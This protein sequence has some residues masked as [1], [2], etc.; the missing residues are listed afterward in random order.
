MY[1]VIAAP[2]F[3]AGAVN[4]TVAW[5]LPGVAVTPVGAPGA[6][7]AAGTTAFDA[8]EGALFPTELCAVTV[9]V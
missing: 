6:T 8:A 4:A 2:P 7:G 1:E 3:D 9:N 5:P